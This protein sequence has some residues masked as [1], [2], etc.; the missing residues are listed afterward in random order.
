MYLLVFICGLGASL[1][2][3]DLG[4]N[5]LETLLAGESWSLMF[6]GLGR[7][8][9]RLVCWF[10]CGIFADSSVSALVD[11]LDV[12]RSDII[13]EVRRKLLLE[14]KCDVSLKWKKKKLPCISHLSSSSSSK[15][16]MYSAT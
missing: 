6:L 3:L 13:S 12:G 11:L 14:P 15:L 9:L 4:S 8:V 16:S 7:P 2:G 1:E 10:E 5:V